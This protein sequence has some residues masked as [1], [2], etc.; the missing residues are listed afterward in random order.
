MKRA[1]LF[2]VLILLGWSGAE[3]QDREVFES[4]FETGNTTEWS[5]ITSRDSSPTVRIIVP[6]SG[7]C[8]T[9]DWDE[10]CEQSGA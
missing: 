1:A 2:F 7:D 3:S 6:V 4:G 9:L 8:T 5:P 10:P